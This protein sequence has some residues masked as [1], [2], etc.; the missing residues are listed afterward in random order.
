MFEYCSRYE[1]FP[2]TMQRNS[3]GFF[4]ARKD[5]C[6]SINSKPLQARTHRCRLCALIV[7]NVCCSNQLQ[8]SAQAWERKDQVKPFA[9][10]AAIIN[11]QRASKIDQMPTRTLST[12]KHAKEEQIKQ[13]LPSLCQAWPTETSEFSHDTPWSARWLPPDHLI[14]D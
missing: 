11:L 4:R 3:Y 7:S 12:K 13:F 1:I 8:T 9:L 6:S 14:L 10:Q 2:R 5:F